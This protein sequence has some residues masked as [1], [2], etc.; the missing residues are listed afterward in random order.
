M[1]R[2]LLDFV[3]ILFFVWACMLLGL[4]II[5][6]IIVPLK[7]PT[8]TNE[9]L[10]GTFKVALSSMLVLFWLWIWREIVKRTFWRTIKK[11]QRHINKSPNE[12]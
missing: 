1:I 11:Q 4:W 3:C 2:R 7:M 8:A 12:N 9:T 6:S 10:T 5:D